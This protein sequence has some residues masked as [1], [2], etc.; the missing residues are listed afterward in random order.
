[1][2]RIELRGTF[3]FMLDD[4]TISSTC[5]CGGCFT[6]IHEL[7][8]GDQ[9]VTSSPNGMLL[10]LTNGITIRVHTFSIGRVSDGD[11]LVKS[12][13][14]MTKEDWDKFTETRQLA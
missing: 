4:K 8:A 13:A 9:V 2:K 5:S 1:M 7:E 3:C 10:K 14:W 11:R 12:T 6:D